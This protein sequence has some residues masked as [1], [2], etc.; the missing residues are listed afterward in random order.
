MNLKTSVA[1]T[2]HYHWSK[3]LVRQIRKS[4]RGPGSSK[5]YPLLLKTFEENGGNID[6][7]KLD[8]LEAAAEG[9]LT[10]VQI[11]KWFWNRRRKLELSSETGNKNRKFPKRTQSVLFPVQSAKCY[12]LLL[13]TF[14]ENGGW[15]DTNKLDE[16][17]TVI[18]VGSRR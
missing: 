11:S 5:C 17:E 4:T 6:R 12:P 2:N 15:A 8:E 13:K 1:E 10:R 9:E 16:I 14:E 7:N 3:N 18:E